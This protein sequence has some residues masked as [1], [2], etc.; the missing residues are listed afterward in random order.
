VRRRDFILSFGGA[1]VGW[2]LTARPAAA[3][4]PKVG[5]LYPGPEAVAEERATHVL[6]GLRSEGFGVPDSITLVIRAT[7]GDSARLAPALS[8]LIA[9][10]VDLL[11]SA[12]PEVTR[13]ARAA[14]TSIP[15][16]AFDLDQDPI[17][18]GLVASLAHP[19]GNVTGVFLD[20]PEFGTTWLELLKGAIPSLASIIVLWDPSTS[21]VQTKAVAAAAQRLGVKIEIL[22][23]KTPAEIGG[24]FEIASA[25]KP[26]GVLLLSSPMMSIHSKQFAD[27]ALTHRLPAISMFE[28]FARS[29]GLMSYG[30]NLNDLYRETG[31]LAGKVLKGTKPAD[32]PVERP[33]RFELLVNLK[34]A[35]ALN[36]DIP[37]AVLARADEVIE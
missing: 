11:I 8:E 22:Q 14:T 32:L 33:S 23:V 36:L 21:T 26:D 31:V 13:A 7:R 17:E 6:E 2:Q 34:T 4:V 16:V 12:G 5:L 25:H 10:K 29:G 30:P 3:S 35:K 19:S 20:F 15:I 37:N 1:V 9:G 24:V 27:L 18:A 28:T